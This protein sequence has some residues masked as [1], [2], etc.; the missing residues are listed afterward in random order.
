MKAENFHRSKK[1][2]K[3]GKVEN[4]LESFKALVKTKIETRRE[5]LLKFSF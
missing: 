1:K 2:I 3:S 4:D 5:F